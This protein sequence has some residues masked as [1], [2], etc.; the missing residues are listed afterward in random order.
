MLRHKACQ[1]LFNEKLGFS[2]RNGLV[3]TLHDGY[4]DKFKDPEYATARGKICNACNSLVFKNNRTAAQKEVDWG[5]SFVRTTDCL[6]RP[7]PTT[8]QGWQELRKRHEDEL[9]SRIQ[10]ALEH[11]LYPAT[12]NSYRAPGNDAN[13]FY[14]MAPIDKDGNVRPDAV[15]PGKE[16]LD[17]LCG[18]ATAVQNE[19]QETGYFCTH[20]GYYEER[21]GAGR[22]YKSKNNGPEPYDWWFCSECKKTVKKPSQKELKHQREASTMHKLSSFFQ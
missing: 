14:G 17:E 16:R 5:P 10:W 20:C 3:E 6:N 9:S 12:E 2:L 15:A 19:D 22:A 21:F 11:E 4:D 1:Q 8:M 7:L 18:F 13:F